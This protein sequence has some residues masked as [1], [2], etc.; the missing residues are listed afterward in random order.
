LKDTLGMINRHQE[1][2]PYPTELDWQRFSS[3]LNARLAELPTPVVVPRYRDFIIDWL[4]KVL[5]PQPSW[6]TNLAAVVTVIL[7]IFQGIILSRPYISIRPIKSIEFR[8][9]EQD[10][11]LSNQPIEQRIALTQYVFN[12]TKS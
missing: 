12:E 3:Q 5:V 4:R 11:Y 9:S 7:L 2:I 8:I 1:P 10:I 6:A